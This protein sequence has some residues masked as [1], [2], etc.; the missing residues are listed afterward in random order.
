MVAS[1]TSQ[2]LATASVKSLI[3]GFVLTQRTDC[4]SPRTIEYYENNLRRFLWYA[5]Q[6][7]WPDDACMITEWHIREFLAYTGNAG[8]RWGLSGNGAESSRPKASYCTVHH[9]YSVL[10]AFFNWCVR[11]GFVSENPLAKIKLR[12]PRLSVV[13]PYSSQDILRLIEVCDYDYKNNARLLGSRNKAIVLMFLDTGLRVSELGNIKLDEIDSERGW[14]KVKGKGAKERVVRMGASAQ[15]ALWRYLV[16]REKVKCENLWVTEEG[17]PMKVGGIQTMLMR[18]KGRA[19]LTAKGNCHR[20]RHTFA[21]HFLR[22]DRNPFN[23]QYL[24]GHS[25]LR[26]VRHYVSTLGMEDALRAHES[27]SPVDT[28]GLR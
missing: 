10:K 15:K 12:A 18:L 27:A 14:I 9:Y 8:N 20:F 16:H 24:L 17:R 2:V 1:V 28:L 21:L 23:L 26:M 19:G 6:E 3:K 4:K 25:D 13:Q 7:Q 5:E 22:K 11:Q